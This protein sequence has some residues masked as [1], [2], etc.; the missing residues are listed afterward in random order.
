MAILAEGKLGVISSKTTAC[1][2]RYRP[3]DVVCV[4]DST[5]RGL[6]VG[7]ALGFGGDIPVVG[8]IEE[9]VAL[10]PDS[11]LIGIAPRGGLLPDE[12]RPVVIAAIRAGLNI[13]SGLHVML[14]EDPEIAPIA[15]REGVEIWDVRAPVIP[16][17]I[18]RG[19]LRQRAGKVVL[20]VGS[21]CSSGKMTVAFELVR[22]LEA[23]GSRARFV[24]TGQTGIILA[25]EGVAVDRVPGDFMARV[26]EDM[27]LSALDSGGLVVVEGQGSLVHP[28]YSGVALAILHGCYPDAMVLCH[29]PSRK[30]I[31]DLAIEIPSLK[32]LIGMYEDLAIP[33]F[34]SR[35][36]AVA[37]NTFDLDDQAAR[38]AV[39]H[40]EET[41]GLPATDV[42]RYGCRKLVAAL[43]DLL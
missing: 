37:L 3:D 8:T 29:Q 12:W 17:G 34:Q 10:R 18:S 20:T 9:A 19:V 32:D 1:V 26:V 36:V 30:W 7:E 25:G 22:Y 21:D 13:V 15:R 40:A 43:G 38:Q 5:K 27:T 4:I 28:A 42:V 2:I 31:D 16:G 6:R 24:A 11:L 14:N 41:T 35:V 39:R 33:V 23:A